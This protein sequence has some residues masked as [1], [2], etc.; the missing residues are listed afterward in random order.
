MFD[1]FHP[2]DIS[3]YLP[4]AK[5]NVGVPRPDPLSPLT[6]HFGSIF[7]PKAHQLSTKHRLFHRLFYVRQ[8]LLQ[9][10]IHQPHIQNFFTSHVQL[11]ITIHQTNKHTL[12]SNSTSPPSSDKAWSGSSV[13]HD[14]L[15][16][17]PGRLQ[18]RQF[19]SHFQSTS[20]DGR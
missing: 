11:L 16:H 20:S 10:H 9:S 7:L 19:D 5:R 6:W 18:R 1:H 4:V 15:C 8:F 12:P 2:M 17:S 3:L 13:P 14:D